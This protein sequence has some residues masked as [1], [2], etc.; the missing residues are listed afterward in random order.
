MSVR[1]VLIL[2]KEYNS[3]TNSESFT[4]AL[5][6]HFLGIITELSE[7]CESKN[8]DIR[9]IPAFDL[10]S[11]DWQIAI[12]QIYEQLYYKDCKKVKN[13]QD[14]FRKAGLHKETTHYHRGLPQK[15][16]CFSKILK[17][18]LVHLHNRRI[19]LQPVPNTKESR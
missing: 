18:F 6:Q 5:V 17:P 3:D 1:D 9:S 14:N 4:F 16:Q 13:H 10:K 7:L 2:T 15:M 11:N 19:R 8:W 12:L